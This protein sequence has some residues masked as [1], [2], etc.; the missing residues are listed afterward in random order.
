M[1]GAGMDVLTLAAGEGASVFALDLLK[2]LACAGMVAMALGRLGVAVI[3]GYVLAGALIGPHAVGI[4]GAGSS[5]EEIGTLATV[6]LMFGI[7]LHLD[8]SS[9][10]RGAATIVTVGV[11]ST[12]GSAVLIAIAGLCFGLSMSASIAIG[13]AL[14]LSSTAV[15]MRILQQRREL[16][17]PHGRLSFGAL[18][19]QDLL[20]IAM[21][22]VLPLLASV[23]DEAETAAEQIADPGG[24]PLLVVRNLIVLALLIVL[25]KLTLPKLMQEAARG[26]SSEVVLVVAAAVALAA[27]VLSGLLGLSPELGAFVAGF[28]LSGTPFRHQLSAQI[29][30][31]RDLFMAVFFTT[32][33]LGLDIGAVV[34]LWWA[35]IIGVVLT[36]AIKAV[37]VTVASWA[38]GVGGAASLRSAAAL[39]QGGEFSV[40]V[41]AAASSLALFD[42]RVEAV[43]MGVVV[44]TLVLT[45]MLIDAGPWLAGRGASWSPPPWINRRGSLEAGAALPAEDDEGGIAEPEPCRVIVAGFGP[46]GRACVERFEQ[47][48]VPV[49]LIELN[50]KTVRTQLALGRRAVFGDVTVPEVLSSAGIDTAEAV[51]LT[52]PD[53]DATLKAVRA[54]RAMRPD[55][56]IGARAHVLSMA[57]RAKDLGADHVIVEELAAA[58]S[59][60][61]ETI[62]RLDAHRNRRISANTADAV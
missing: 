47:A 30:P 29:S 17:T 43:V 4:V 46:V 55:V 32:V 40:V 51:L 27:A 18:L 62:E 56:F 44:V 37:S 22:A 38:C 13:M 34:P 36:I 25:G 14:S 20:V 26:A 12:L 24:G 1:T 61:R 21:L 11:A 8:A 19:M 59:M 28:L 16:Y 39:A 58:E 7:G 50:A 53:Q 9:L 33:G 48:G 42:E 6:M 52:I 31:I 23:P 60:S 10:R 57:M 41:L 5:A 15:V 3:P 54:V 35:L 49:S 45:P 2:I